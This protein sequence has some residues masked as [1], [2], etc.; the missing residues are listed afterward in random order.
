MGRVLE[1]LRETVLLNDRVGRLGEAAEKLDARQS[2]SRDRVTR[3]E[4]IIEFA[5]SAKLPRDN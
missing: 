3:N 5:R 2:S 4:A 1:A